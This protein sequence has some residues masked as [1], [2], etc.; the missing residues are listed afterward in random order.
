MDQK[1]FKLQLR[2]MISNRTCTWVR[3]PIWKVWKYKIACLELEQ[4]NKEFGE[5]HWQLENNIEKG[6]FPKTQ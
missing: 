5:K 2:F 6:V 4:E 1:L 3:R